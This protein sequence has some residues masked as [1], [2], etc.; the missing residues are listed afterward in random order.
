MKSKRNGGII[1]GGYKGLSTALICLR[2]L[3]AWRIKNTVNAHGKNN[4]SFLSMPAV[5]FKYQTLLLM[6]FSPQ[7]IYFPPTRAYFGAGNCS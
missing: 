5:Y 6:Y 7:S 2:R 1:L 4:Y 3:E